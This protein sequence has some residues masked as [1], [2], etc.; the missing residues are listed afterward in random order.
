MTDESTPPLMPTTTRVLLLS[1]IL[2]PSFQLDSEIIHDL[3]VVTFQFFSLYYFFEISKASRA[4]NEK[5]LG[6]KTQPTS[7][8]FQ[9]NRKPEGT[10]YFHLFLQVSL[11]Y[12]TF[13]NTPR[14]IKPSIKKKY[15]SLLISC[16]SFL[17]IF[18]GFKPFA[19]V[20]DIFNSFRSAVIV[21]F[22]LK[23]SFL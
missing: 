5:I 7:C 18:I 11:N 8:C 13:S 9:I 6:T 23:P 17:K 12:S 16:C 21:I 19:V 15:F 4:Y 22:N 10:S 14:L 2:S 3:K 20:M 1:A